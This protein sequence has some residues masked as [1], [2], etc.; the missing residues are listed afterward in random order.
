MTLHALRSA[1]PHTRE[2][3]YVNHAA[4]G[5]FSRPV[6]AALEAYL[7]ARSGG[8]IEHWEAFQPVLQRALGRLGTTIGA[9]PDR[10][11]FAAS[12]SDALSVLAEG[13]DWQPGDRVAVPGCEFPANVY[14]FLHLRSRGVETDFIPHQ[15]GT[16]TLDAIAGALTPR[17]RVVSVSWVQF[18]SGFRLDLRAVAD[19]VHAHGALLCVDAIQGVGALPLDVVRDGV[20]FL[21]CG[22]QKWLMA[23]RG[24]AF[25]YVN[26]NTQER[27]RPRAGWLHGPVDWDDFFAYDLQFFPD[28]RR[29]QPGTLN[30]IAITALDAAL[31]LYLDAGLDAC[32]ER[33][34]ARAAELRD[35][36]TRQGLDLYG[37][38]DP[39]HASG[40][41][42]VRHPDPDAAFAALRAAGIQ[43]SLRNR[44][45]RFSPT[46]Y[47]TAEEM[48]QVLGV[49]AETLPSTGT[50]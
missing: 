16:L 1:F 19:L 37:S 13:L 24:L 3:V 46:W 50:A 32:G 28:A 48:E 39:A 35:G 41:V 27:L 30:Q 8:D 2:T 9:G 45:L 7:Q 10:I 40:I 26:E 49:I 34:L 25:L 14:P 5:V 42:T 18:L 12:T 36:L 15:D 23:P 20:D 29:F 4:T 33:V 6:V 43:A 38:P 11:A 31:G 17:T 22:V 47:N 21:A 44:L